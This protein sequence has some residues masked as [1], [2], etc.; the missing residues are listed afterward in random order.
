MTK[1]IIFYSFLFS[2]LIFSGVTDEKKLEQSFLGNSQESSSTDKSL[3]FNKFID[4]ELEKL[5][6]LKDS[7]IL[8]RP[9][10]EIVFL[11]SIEKANL[12][13][14]FLKQEIYKIYLPRSPPF[15]S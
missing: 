15:F 13:D 4:T 1:L 9:K 5:P 7:K 14:F 2:A 8:Y 11:R 10:L 6:E 12:T 3:S